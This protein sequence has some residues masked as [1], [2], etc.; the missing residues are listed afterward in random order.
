MHFFLQPTC[1]LP[2]LLC[3]GHRSLPLPCDCCSV[4]DR[5]ARIDHSAGTEE[6]QSV[7][8]SALPRVVVMM[9]ASDTFD[10]HDQT[11]TAASAPPLSA[12][13]AGAN[14]SASHTAAASS[15]APPRV[16]RPSPPPSEM[17]LNHFMSRSRLPALRERLEQ[18]TLYETKAKLYLVGSPANGSYYRVLK[19]DRLATDFAALLSAGSSAFQD[20]GL[21]YDARELADLLRMIDDGNASQGG[22]KEIVSNCCGIIGFVRFVQGYYMILALSR[23]LVGKIGGHRVY[24]VSGSTMVP[25]SHPSVYP[26]APVS[27]TKSAILNSIRRSPPPAPPTSGA[28]AAAFDPKSKPNEARYKSIFQGLDLNKN[29]YFCPTGYELTQTLQAQM[30]HA[31]R[32][33]HSSSSSASTAEGTDSAAHGGGGGAACTERPP[34]VRSMFLWNNFLLSK[35]YRLMARQAQEQ[36]QD[37]G[38][39]L[40]AT[41]AGAGAGARGASSD[42]EDDEEEEEEEE[43]SEEGE[44]SFRPTLPHSERPRAF[45]PS[46]RR[47]HLN[48][49]SAWALPLIH[50]YLVQ[51]HLS[52]F[53]NVVDLTLLARRSRFFAGTRYLKRGMNNSGRVA[54]D[55]EIEQIAWMRNRG[56]HL[57]GQFTS[58]VQVR[59][60]IP[61][62]WSQEGNPLVAQPAIV[63]NKTDPLHLSTR[64]HLENL[65]RRYGSP[66]LVL[67]LVKQGE[68]PT[69]RR[70]SIIGEALA[71]SIGFI[72]KFMQA[73]HK[74]DLS[75]HTHAHAHAH[76]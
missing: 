26:V 5:L 17:P 6:S 7:A 70:E 38:E 67:N 66:L 35:F 59:G 22:L 24:E 61:L 75:A 21:R 16:A 73:E 57:E 1:P 41:G 34:K 29:F 44:E 62:F 68:R 14:G 13:A 65:L 19:I 50:G 49:A 58:Y 23:R 20:D 46:S 10:S 4:T 48:P 37:E 53:G 32:Q 51:T 11:A 2:L 33:P 39:G 72:N 12:A 36:Q 3:C 71:E 74:I 45:S 27:S 8:A 9:A 18:F 55:V 56:S 76:A 30:L 15:S 52:V 60:S 42:D 40:E 69:R 28:A 63:V 43:G 25:I 64:C 47:A 31:G 54:N